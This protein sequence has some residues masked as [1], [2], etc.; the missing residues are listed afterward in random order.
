M[1][2]LKYK[3]FHADII[4]LNV[5]WYLAYPL[6]YRNLEEMMDDRGINIDHTS[7]YRWVQEYSPNL[8]KNFNK[9]KRPVAG[10]WRMDETYIKVRGKWK[11]LYRAVDKQGKTVDFMLSSKR[12]AS[13]AASF[14]CRAIGNNGVPDKINIDKSGANTAGI[15]LYNHIEST[16]IEIRRCKYLNNIVEG[17]HFGLK[18]TLTSV[19]GFKRM[20][21]AKNSIYGAEV[22]RMIRKDQLEP[23]GLV[24]LSQYE[25]FKSL[26]A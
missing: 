1:K 2:R 6:S 20:K 14:L 8:V 26:V 13:A 9:R 25:S 22:I 10:S 18:R 12:D 15:N 21:S 4:L 3:H 17:D 19:T 11:Y 16:S 7:I 23:C 5:R 24:R